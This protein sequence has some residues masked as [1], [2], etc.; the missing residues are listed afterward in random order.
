[1]GKGRILVVDDQERWRRELVE[2]LH[3][4]GYE[5]DA[6]SSIGE[7]VQLLNTRLYHVLALDIRMNDQDISNQEGIDLLKE[8]NRQGLTEAIKIIVISG[9]ST[10]EQTRDAFKDF[11]VA[12]VLFK[13]DL[14]NRQDFLKAVQQIFT[15][16]NLELVI[17]WQRID[18]AAQAVLNL[19]VKETAVE[20]GTPLQT[21]VANELVDLLCRLFYRAKSILVQP[22][23]S[24]H[25]GMKVLRIK[26]FYTGGG[27]HDVVVKFG[28]ARMI[29]QE[30]HGFKEY[31]QPFLGGGRNTTVLDF[32]R[33]LHLGGII[34]SLLGTIDD[35]LVNFGAFYQRS[36]TPQIKTTLERLFRNTCGG[37][38]A[39]CGNQEPL[40]LT[41]DYQKLLQYSLSTI[42]QRILKQLGVK[43]DPELRFKRLRGN[44]LFTNPMRALDSKSYVYPTYRCITHGDFNQH[45]L[46]V[47]GDGHV[48]MI[49]FQGTSYSHFLRDI[50][51]LDTVVRIQL[52]HDKDATLRER[53]LME[54]TLCRIERFSHVEQLESLFET[55]NQALAK[56]YAVVVY[57]RTLPHKLMYQNPNDD[58]REYYVALLYHALNALNFS[59]LS[60]QQHEHALLSASLLTDRLLN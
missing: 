14:F 29:Q 49:D 26:P 13:N 57:L 27:G 15:T 39:N 1:M 42:E 24:G 45:N 37:W 60:I 38:Y 17:H 16:I 12:D 22:L 43:S 47:D 31:V 56:T 50:A 11:E 35:Q 21:Q 36:D 59:S 3:G 52:L 5:A 2:T 23:V 20:A 41:E 48:W 40:D 46:L 58:M 53:L 9:Y 55:K 19:K 34:Y 7:A 32:R 10:K 8:L 28:D 6:A 25:S 33:T 44:R 51:M 18:G 4:A 30:H 54:E